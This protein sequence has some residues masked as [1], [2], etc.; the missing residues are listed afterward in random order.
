LDPQT[1]C[2]TDVKIG[3]QGMQVG[4]YPYQIFGIFVL[5]EMEVFQ[6]GGYLADD[7]GLGKVIVPASRCTLNRYH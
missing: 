2:S 3:I 7:M 4:F 6:N 1:D 5:F